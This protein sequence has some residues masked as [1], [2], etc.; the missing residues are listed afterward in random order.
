MISAAMATVTYTGWVAWARSLDSVMLLAYA[1]HGLFLVS[2]MTFVSPNERLDYGWCYLLAS[3]HVGICWVALLVVARV[4]SAMD[5]LRGQNVEPDAF[6][7]S[8]DR[9]ESQVPVVIKMPLGPR[10]APQDSSQDV[11]DSRGCSACKIEG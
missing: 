2:V 7:E 5:K 11:D 4:R 6:A 3:A 9:L 10:Q 1:S 8:A